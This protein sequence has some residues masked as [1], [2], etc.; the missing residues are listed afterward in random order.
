MEKDD[1]SKHLTHLLVISL[2]HQPVHYPCTK[3]VK[4]PPAVFVKLMVSEVQ[5]ESVASYLFSVAS[6]K[7]ECSHSQTE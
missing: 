7:A 2:H 4:L 5:G 1:Q 3:A 6:A